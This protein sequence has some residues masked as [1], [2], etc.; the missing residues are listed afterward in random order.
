MS[1]R[2]LAQ[3]LG[4]IGKLPPGL[5]FAVIVLYAL[6]RMYKAWQT[7]SATGS[8][9]RR[10]W[11][12]RLR[13]DF[14][15]QID[16]AVE[17]SEVHCEDKIEGI[18]Y[19]MQKEIDALKDQLERALAE[20]SSAKSWEQRAWQMRELALTAGTER[21]EIDKAW[22]IHIGVPGDPPPRA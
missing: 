20:L 2:L 8:K 21:S 14:Q 15:K 10:T 11:E 19:G 7:H 17:K 4:E 5:L 13:E 6:E 3:D 9:D 1:I 16:T 22:L 12:E 18:R